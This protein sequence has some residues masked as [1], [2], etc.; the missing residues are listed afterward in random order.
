MQSKAYI[1]E[2]SIIT[3]KALYP[4]HLT[5]SYIHVLFVSFPVA[6]IL[7]VLIPLAIDPHFM[8][9]SQDVSTVNV[10][11]TTETEIQLYVP[12][13]RATINVYMYI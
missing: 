6:P 5:M 3:F 10:N 12:P 1:G 11:S 2:F 13:N 4:V 7:P 9:S 8:V